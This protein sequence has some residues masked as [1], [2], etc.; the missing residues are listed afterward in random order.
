VACSTH[1]TYGN[2][3][4]KSYSEDLFGN[5]HSGDVDIEGRIILK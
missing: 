2:M 3:L 5:E 1:A 4:I